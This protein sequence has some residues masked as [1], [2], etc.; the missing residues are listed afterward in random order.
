MLVQYFLKFFTA[1]SQW[2]NLPTCILIT[3]LDRESTG[4][5][6]H[7][8]FSVH[9]DLAGLSP[10]CKTWDQYSA[11][12]ASELGCTRCTFLTQNM[13]K[14]STY[15]LYRT[16]QSI[17]P[18]KNKLSSWILYS[19]MELRWNI[20]HNRTCRFALVQR[21]KYVNK[22]TNSRVTQLNSNS[23]YGSMTN[24]WTLPLMI[25]RYNSYRFCENV[26]FLP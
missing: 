9:I 6:W 17:P 8:V 21:K 23:M 7:S 18:D 24:K 3:T 19:D 5:N 22:I 20:W 16:F 10:Y 11:S 26:C 1:F 12:T 2:F 14:E 15:L 25:T 13:I 4:E